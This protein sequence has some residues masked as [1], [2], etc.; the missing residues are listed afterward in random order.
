MARGDPSKERKGAAYGIK[1]TRSGGDPNA[2]AQPTQGNPL[3]P[4]IKR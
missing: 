2:H 1:T 3:P 4:T